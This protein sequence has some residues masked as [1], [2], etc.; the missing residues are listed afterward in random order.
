VCEQLAQSRYLA[1]EW[2]G[3][4]PATFG[5]KSDTVTI[6]GVMVT[7][8]IAKINNQSHMFV[9]KI[10]YNR[11]RYCYL[12]SENYLYFYTTLLFVAQLP[13]EQI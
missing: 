5:R 8:V 11:L 6:S 2:L 3:I 9:C 13:T 4:E 12:F 1:V 10:V 7:V